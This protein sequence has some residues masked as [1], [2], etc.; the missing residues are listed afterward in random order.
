MIL[1]RVATMTV[2]AE[3]RTRVATA[4]LARYEVTDNCEHTMR[5]E[6]FWLDL[7]LTP[8]LQH[9]AACYPDHWAADRFEH[10]GELFCVP[11]GELLR[12]RCEAGTVEAVICR[13]D[14]DVVGRWFDGDLCWTGWCLGASLDI[15]NQSIRCLLTRLSKELRHPGFASEMLLELVA[16]QLAIELAR[17]CGSVRHSSAAGSLAEWRLKL[18]DER[19]H[20]MGRAPSLAELASLCALSVR[21]LSRGFRVSRGCSIGHYVEQARVE[22]AK[23]MLMSG[24]SA[25][26]VADLMGFASISSFSY[27]FR[28]ATGTCPTRFRQ[29]A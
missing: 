23:R 3:L 16:S 22:S 17:Y 13:I 7:C 20:V 29:S 2:E 10:I 27:S 9:A 26:A 12:A 8:R 25:K 28:R 5:P 14:P 21:Q 15:R 11:P 6:A 4:Q 1:N 19:V 18:I 24:Q